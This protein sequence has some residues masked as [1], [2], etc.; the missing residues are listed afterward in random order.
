MSQKLYF[1]LIQ[2]SKSD[3]INLS[4]WVRP[5]RVFFP[6]SV[7]LL[8]K[9]KGPLFAASCMDKLSIS[10]VA[11]YSFCPPRNLQ[12]I[13]Q[14]LM[15]LRIKTTRIRQKVCWKIEIEKGQISVMANK[16]NY[17]KKYWF[18]TSIQG[19]SAGWFLLIVLALRKSL[20]CWPVVIA[21]CH[22]IHLNSPTW[23][24]QIHK[25][26]CSR[27]KFYLIINGL[28]GLGLKFRYRFPET[29]AEGAK[30]RAHCLRKARIAGQHEGA[31][32]E[33]FVLGTWKKC[34]P[35][36]AQCVEVMVLVYTQTGIF[37]Y[38]W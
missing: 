20:N 13:I 26:H 19:H 5:L 35:W 32:D 14:C 28:E 9:E 17:T 36:K 24:F 27:R 8:H 33:R 23:K 4:A 12:R 1:W 2:N 30:G 25:L 10:T 6:I 31:D 37:A 16:V 7:S 29:P 38:I 15:P 34:G 3:L 21:G 18:C 11:L 22:Q